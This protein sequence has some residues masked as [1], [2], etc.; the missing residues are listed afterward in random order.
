M[1]LIHLGKLLGIVPPLSEVRWRFFISMKVSSKI[2]A[3]A[4]VASIGDFPFRCL[5]ADHEINKAVAITYSRTH[6][7]GYLV[8]AFLRPKPWC[9]KAFCW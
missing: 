5:I 1:G 3:D 8:M 7:F 2:K 9:C 4:P 6:V